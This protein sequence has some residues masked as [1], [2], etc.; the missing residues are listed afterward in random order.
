MTPHLAVSA[1]AVVAVA[2]VATAAVA[3]PVQAEPTRP[4][5]PGQIAPSVTPTRLQPRWCFTVTLVPGEVRLDKCSDA[6]YTAFM[7]DA[8]GRVWVAI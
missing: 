4:A 1:G 6:T 7:W 5:R 3:L 2:A 8:Q